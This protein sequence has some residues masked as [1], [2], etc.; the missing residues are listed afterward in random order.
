MFSNLLDSKANAPSSPSHMKVFWSWQSDVPG[1][2][3]RHFVRD[4]LAKA[5]DQLKQDCSV[6]EATRK[7]ELDHDRKGVP[8]SPDL[9]P[10][11]LS[12]IQ[13][14]SVFVADVT[15]VGQTNRGKPLIN[16]NVAIEL[17][18][19]MAHVKDERI[20][21]V[22]N[23]AYGAREDLP[24]DLRHKAGPILYSF[25]SSNEGQREAVQG[26]LASVLKNALR[27]SLA[28][29]QEPKI[30]E[31]LPE[32]RERRQGILEETVERGQ[33]LIVR[34]AVG[35]PVEPEGDKG[36]LHLFV[37][38][39]NPVPNLVENA[40]EEIGDDFLSETLTE[41]IR[42]VGRT[43]RISPDF[44]S[45]SPTP[46]IEGWKFFM[47]ASPRNSSRRSRDVLDLVVGDD[48]EL[49]LHCGRAGDD[50]GSD[51]F[52]VIEDIVAEISVKFLAFCRGLYE[53]TGFEG[54]LDAGAS[55]RG[56]AGALP[57]EASRRRPF[58]SS[59]VGTYPNDNYSFTLSIESSR[60]EKPADVAENLL[61]RFF[62][63]LT[64]GY[65]DPFQS[66]QE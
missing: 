16:S 10:T 65:Y 31:D 7:L 56:I 22:L 52:K 37:R 66:L 57:V 54:A 51:T 33:A 44:R 63:G 60:L 46:S 61:R 19:A 34:D 1:K 43:G 23:S 17:G 18:F 29:A 64:G 14:C 35:D 38:P 13:E 32:D 6:E 27:D 20:L 15:P 4:A 26:G 5:I 59:D 53:A 62:R 9:A 3:G 24:F 12:K 55:V 49:E 8:G 11:I 42:Q 48:G 40:R 58:F 2:Y 39:I 21:M 25:S 41:A 36:W 30:A 50:W 28:A 45:V 47:D